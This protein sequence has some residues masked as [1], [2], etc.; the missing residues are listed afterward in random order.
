MFDGSKKSLKIA[1]DAYTTALKG[2]DPEDCLSIDDLTY[3]TSG[4]NGNCVHVQEWIDIGKS[5]I[6]N[7]NWRYADPY[8]YHDY[9]GTYDMG[10]LPKWAKRN[11][12]TERTATG[13][14]DD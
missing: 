4:L 7:D 6:L 10:Y 11:I 14:F 8:N 1:Q 12:W 2:I 3:L 9:Y 13:Y 5:L